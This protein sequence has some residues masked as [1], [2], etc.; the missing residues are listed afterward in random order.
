MTRD[1][2]LDDDTRPA[3]VPVPWAGAPAAC[4]AVLGA[5]GGIALGVLLGP[6]GI[7]VGG[8]LGAIGGAGIGDAL[9]KIQEHRTIHE[10]LVDEELGV[11]DGNVGVASPDQPP[12]WIGAYSAGSAGVARGPFDITPDSGPIPKAD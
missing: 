5:L 12:A 2:A 7:L 10:E 11:I 6:A 3:G 8:L 9:G 4:G 1:V